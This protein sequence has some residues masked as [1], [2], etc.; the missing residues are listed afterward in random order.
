MCWHRAGV[1]SCLV[2]GNGSIVA[3]SGLVLCLE[4]HLNSFLRQPP[5]HLAHCDTGPSK[6]MVVPACLGG[7]P[8]CYNPRALVR[9]QIHLCVY[10]GESCP[11]TEAFLLVSVGTC[12]LRTKSAPDSTKGGFWLLMFFK[13][14]GFCPPDGS[15]CIFPNRF[16]N[17]L[18]SP[19]L[20]MRRGWCSTEWGP[21]RWLRWVTAAGSPAG[22]LALTAEYIGVR[23]PLTCCRRS[24]H[25][26][27]PR[28]GCCRWRRVKTTRAST[29]QLPLHE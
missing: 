7:Q 25:A 2:T 24:Q 12:G 9:F 15:R 29:P 20:Q 14:A 13:E 26:L 18:A 21:G 10:Q 11:H 3:D 16:S 1:C 5:S 17:G 28:A 6:K 22:T 4:V 27:Q 23:R 19:W 8:G